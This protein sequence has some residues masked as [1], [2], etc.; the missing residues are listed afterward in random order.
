MDKHPEI[1]ELWRLLVEHHPLANRYA[2]FSQ[3]TRNVEATDAAANRMSALVSA[4]E[5]ACH[6]RGVAVTDISA[7]LEQA[8]RR[9]LDTRQIATLTWAELCQSRRGVHSR[10]YST[11]LVS[12]WLAD[13]ANAAFITLAEAADRLAYEHTRSCGTLTEQ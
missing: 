13:F 9:L 3:Q 7:R 11:A 12:G 6:S 2:R 10:V 5:E 4:Y 8:A 1:D